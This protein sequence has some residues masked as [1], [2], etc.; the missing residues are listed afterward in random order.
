MEK[1]L[2]LRARRRSNLVQFGGI[3]ASKLRAPRDDRVAGQRVDRVDLSGLAMTMRTL[4][5]S[6]I[7]LSIAGGS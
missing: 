6:K 1:A 4:R 5:L 2:S 7:G 3:A